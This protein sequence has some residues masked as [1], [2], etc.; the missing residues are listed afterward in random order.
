MKGILKIY[1]P[2]ETMK[3]HLK[4]TYCKAVYQNQKHLL[5]LDIISDDSLDH[6]DDDS[7]QYNYPQIALEIFEYLLPGEELDKLTITMSEEDAAEHTEVDIFD[8]DDAYLLDN[9]LSF[10]R[11]ESGVLY[12]V[13]KGAINDFYTN[14]EHAIPFKLKCDFREE[15]LQIAED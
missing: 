9:E 14:S 15:E 11:D 4:S 7:L 13:W 12:L 5:E 2:D 1:H 10:T 6:V 8:D 3:Y